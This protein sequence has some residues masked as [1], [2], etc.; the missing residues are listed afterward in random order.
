MRKRKWIVLCSVLV[1]LIAAMIFMFSAQDGETSSE[2]SGEIVTWV[3]R[4]FFPDFQRL[5]AAEQKAFMQRVS[6]IVRKLAHF[7][8]FALLG[9]ALRLLFY[10]LDLRRGLLWAWAA[11]TLYACTDELHQMF[12]A[13]RGPSAGDVLIDSAGVLTLACLTSLLLLIRKR[14]RKLKSV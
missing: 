6:Y 4:T 2:T 3:I 10:T 1:F 9:G 14:S 11:G 5:T 7:T 13:S 8:E 12:V